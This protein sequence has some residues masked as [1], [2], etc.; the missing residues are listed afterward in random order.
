VNP[1]LVDLTVVRA[2]DVV[3]QPWKNGGGV[4]REL[5]RLA[6][7]GGGADDWL[8]RISVA[9]IGADGP[10]SAFPGIRRSLAVLS[11]QGVQLE[12]PAGAPFSSPMPL[13][14]RS[15]VLEFDGLQAPHCRLIDGPTC[16][17]N[18]MTRAT[19]ASA[20]VTRAGHGSA[21]LRRLDAAGVFALEP[22]T[23]IRGDDRI[24]LPARTLAWQHAPDTAAW[25]LAPPADADRT[26]GQTSPGAPPAYWIGLVLNRD[27]A[28]TSHP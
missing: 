25:S 3:P 13:T 22:I 21:S 10:F 23:L 19:H 6:L 14:T 28:P 20:Y 16:D 4:T 5:L 2:G 1:A 26:L 11:G 7:P 17:L 9:D 24:T 27:A 12:W 18:V 8:L 15:R